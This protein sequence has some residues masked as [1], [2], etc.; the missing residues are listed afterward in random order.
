MDWAVQA[1]DEA[2]GLGIETWLLP[3]P[4]TPIPFLT[5]VT[6]SSH[7]QAHAVCVREAWQGGG[8]EFICGPCLICCEDPS[9]TLM[10]RGKGVEPVGG[11]LPGLICIALRTHP[12]P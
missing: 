6:V 7:S 9:H 12:T 11:S 8:R 2:P 10:P 3:A 4:G 5:W 1:L